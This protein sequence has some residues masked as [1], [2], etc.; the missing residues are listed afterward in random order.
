MA[1]ILKLKKKAADFEAKK[2]MELRNPEKAKEIL[3]AVPLAFPG[4]DHRCQALADEALTRYQ[5]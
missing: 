4:R 3:E 1:D 5:L 2:Q